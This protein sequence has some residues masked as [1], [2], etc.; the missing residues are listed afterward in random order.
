[1]SMF[2]RSYRFWPRTAWNV[3]LVY[4]LPILLVAIL[5]LGLLGGRYWWL[6]ALVVA[7]L[8]QRKGTR[9]AWW[10]A[11]VWR[12]W[13]FRTWESLGKPWADTDAQAL[14][15]AIDGVDKEIGGRPRPAA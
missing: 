12:A 9:R 6:F 8:G 4:V 1:M 10:S 3:P 5:A 14:A 2:A 11:V 13:N 7:V 15:M